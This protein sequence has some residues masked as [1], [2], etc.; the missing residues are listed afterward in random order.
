MSKIGIITDTHFGEKIQNHKRFYEL[1]GRFLNNIFF[2]TLEKEG[3]K[4]LLHGGDLFH[5]R[6]S[7]DIRTW[8]WTQD[9]FLD[10]LERLGISM[11]GIVGNHD[12]YYKSSSTVNSPREFLRHYANCHFVDE[13]TTLTFDNIKFLLLPWIHNYNKNDMLKAIQ[14]SDASYVLSHLELAGFQM[15][16]GVYSEQG[17]GIENYLEKFKEVWSGHYHTQSQKGNIRYL[18]A[19]IEFN[20]N[21]YN[22]MKGF[23]IFDTQSERLTFY[24]NP[25]SLH[26]KIYLGQDSESLRAEDYKDKI[27]RLIITDKIPRAKIDATVSALN[28]YCWDLKIIDH[29]IEGIDHN[30][31]DEQF[32]EGKSTLQII[33]ETVRETETELDQNKLAHLIKT[34]YMEAE[35]IR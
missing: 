34:L 1:Y 9:H 18:G 23:H 28:E 8:K 29:N 6:H 26:Y 21:D 30:L 31:Q 14:D 19:P 3:V 17:M 25:E 35:A 5:N 33:D 12:T 27:V 16:P 20:W 7:V 24:R 4:H 32:G 11:Y 15:H 13:A 22:D 10:R 2:P